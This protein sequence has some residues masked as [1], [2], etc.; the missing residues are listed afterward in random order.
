VSIK[1]HYATLG[2]SPDCPQEQIK[3]A[4]RQLVLLHHPDQ[5]PS[6]EAAVERF[7]EIKEAYDILSDPAARAAYD[8]EFVRAFPG[9]ELEGG[10]EEPYWQVNP[11][12][13]MPVVRD[14]GSNALLRILMVM[15][16]P[17]IVGGLAMNFTGEAVW[18]LI[19]AVAGLLAAVWLGSFLRDD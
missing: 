7:L 14:E 3:A 15:I 5:N 2:L 8:L 1:N 6:D 12:A 11:P 16:L 13:S 17:I 18:A 4:Y 9:Y 19:G 10:E